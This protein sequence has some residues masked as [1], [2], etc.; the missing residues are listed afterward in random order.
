M[1]NKKPKVVYTIREASGDRKFWRPIGAAFENKDG[2]L[3]VVLDS[4]PIDGKLHI[5]DA[6]EDERKEAHAEVASASA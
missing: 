5:R 4:L 6:R 1:S 2:S 3:N